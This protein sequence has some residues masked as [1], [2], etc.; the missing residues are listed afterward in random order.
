MAWV[1]VAYHGISAT[2]LAMGK[3]VIMH[4]ESGYVYARNQISNGMNGCSM[5]GIPRAR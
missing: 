4:D 5:H 3:V 1:G 2:K